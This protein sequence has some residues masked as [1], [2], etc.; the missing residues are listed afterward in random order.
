MTRVIGQNPFTDRVGLG[1]IF[2]NLM[3]THLLCVCIEFCYENLLEFYHEWR[4]LIGYATHNG[5]SVVDQFSY[6]FIF[7]INIIPRLAKSL[8]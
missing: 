7:H 6:Y 5:Y 2:L 3:R 1:T 8:I 4:S